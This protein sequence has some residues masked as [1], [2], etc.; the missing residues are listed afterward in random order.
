MLGWCADAVLHL[1]NG[2]VDTTEFS[3]DGEVATAEPT[4][5]GQA[6]V[7]FESVRSTG[8][9]VWTARAGG[10]T[11]PTA[12]LNGVVYGAVA[13]YSLARTDGVE[14]IRADGRASTNIVLTATDAAG[15]P[16]PGHEPRFIRVTQ[17]V[18]SGTAVS[19]VG[20]ASGSIPSCT[21]TDDGGGTNAAGRCNVRVTASMTQGV[22][23]VRLGATSAT[24]GISATIDI[25]LVG[26]NATLRFV[27]APAEVEAGSMTVIMI[28]VVDAEGDPGADGQA[29][30][31]QTGEI[32]ATGTGAV[33]RSGSP[34]VA[35]RTEFTFVAGEVEGEAIIL[36]TL[37]DA[38]GHWTIQVRGGMLSTPLPPPPPTTETLN[39]A[40]GL[41]GIGW[42][43]ADTTSAQLLADN[44]TIERIWWLDPAGV[45]QVDSLVL[46]SSLRVTIQ[47]TRGMAFYVVNS[48]PLALEV[49]LS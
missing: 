42:F 35:G 3:D 24:S 14:F 39:V 12:T 30:D 26:A 18:A 37:G 11:G 16:V 31:G 45:W 23:T 13:D 41:Q 29:F 46:P 7:H 2:V 4:G 1:R 44:A 22:N 6:S 40:A 43:G 36:V 47:I 17:P 38:Q 48:G 5:T 21:V 15:N 49:P 20:M 10:A 33:S 19:A 27:D 25:T 9:V 34:T 28:E 32:V 8:T